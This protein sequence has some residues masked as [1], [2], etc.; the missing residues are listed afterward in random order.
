MNDL[1]KNIKSYYFKVLNNNKKRKGYLISYDKIYGPNFLIYFVRQFWF[2]NLL[3]QVLT[4][5]KILFVLFREFWTV[6]SKKI[7]KTDFKEKKKVPY[8]LGVSSC[9]V[10]AFSIKR[11]W[12]TSFFSLLLTK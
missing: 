7:R 10:L 5:S 1:L 4:V 12:R 3:T 9:W 2:I 11:K 8:F 6:I